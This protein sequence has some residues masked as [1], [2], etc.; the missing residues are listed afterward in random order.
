LIGG[1][2][3]ARYGE[4]RGFGFYKV[5]DEKIE[6]EC[7]D[8]DQ[9]VG[10]LQPSISPC[11]L[12]SPLRQAQ[13]EV[14][15]I[16]SFWHNGI[17]AEVI[18]LLL[19]RNPT[20]VKQAMATSWIPRPDTYYAIRRVGLSTGKNTGGNHPTTVLGTWFEATSEAT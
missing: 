3:F 10:S 19:D 13:R 2:G 8:S 16:H 5:P 15:A 12:R 20:Q 17:I 14:D 9:K 7:A 18:K 1:F 11:R 4:R 6:K